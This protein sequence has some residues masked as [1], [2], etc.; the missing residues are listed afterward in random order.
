MLIDPRKKVTDKQL[1]WFAGLWFPAFCGVVFLAM[2]RRGAQT[3]AL[4][5]VV[6]GGVLS[7]AGLIAP[8]FIRPVYGALMWITFPLGWVMS[9][10]LLRVAYY[11][12]ITPVGALVRLF[13]D[14]LE[15]RFDRSADSYW[16]P[17]E[18]SKRGRYF[19]QF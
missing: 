9:H 10:V 3:A 15:R 18:P 11:G 19:R 16:V 17:H 12:V 14:P 8:R 7:V 13:R 1:R 6:A 2:S 5:V 4:S